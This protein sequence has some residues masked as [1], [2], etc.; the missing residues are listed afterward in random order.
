MP[1]LTPS[2]FR[3]DRKELLADLPRFADGPRNVRFRHIVH[4]YVDR[5]TPFNTE[6]QAITFETIRIAA[7]AAPDIATRCVCVTLADEGHIVPPDCLAVPGLTRMAGDVA[8]FKHPRPLPLLFDSIDLG[9]AADIGAA[10]G[11]EFV[12]FTNSDIHLLP[13]FYRSIARLI[14]EGYDVITVNRRV[15]PRQPGDARD[16]ALMFADYGKDHPGFDCFVFPARLYPAFVKSNACVGAGMVM[17]SLL[18]NLAALAGRFLML[19]T[20]H[21]TFHIGE[22]SFWVNPK[23]ADYVDFNLRQAQEVVAGFA[24]RSPEREK[25]AGFLRA[26]G[27]KKVFRRQLAGI[28]AP[29]TGGA[30]ASAMRRWRG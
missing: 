6:V 2:F 3:Q 23:Y 8:P 1:Q 5:S 7:A 12:I 25:L 30:L 26:N 4:P 16:L 13:H 22:D 24:A 9:V 11:E 10:D 14:A 29:Q 15:I 18:F 21:L 17:R 28:A 20:P 27:E 19:T